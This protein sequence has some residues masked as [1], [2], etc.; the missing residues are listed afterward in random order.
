LAKGT[1]LDGLSS[2]STRSAVPLAL[3]TLVTSCSFPLYLTISPFSGVNSSSS[4]SSSSSSPSS[5]SFF[6]FEVLDEVFEGFELF[7]GELFEDFFECDF[8]GAS[9]SS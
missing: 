5:S 6:D 2:A 1:A 8:F 4:S 3:L 7:F 9:S